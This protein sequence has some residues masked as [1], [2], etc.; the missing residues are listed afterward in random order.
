M[1]KTNNKHVNLIIMYLIL[2]NK[3]G[4]CDFQSVK[5]TTDIQIQPRA[6]AVCQNSPMKIELQRT[7]TQEETKKK[8]P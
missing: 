7:Q 6:P 4:R 2:C 3:Q 1:D 5:L 8:K